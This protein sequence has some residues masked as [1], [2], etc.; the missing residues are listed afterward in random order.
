MGMH[1]LGPSPA[2]QKRAKEGADVQTGVARLVLQS[3]DGYM[4]SFA[5]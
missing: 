2:L 3:R 5:N 4:F 1:N